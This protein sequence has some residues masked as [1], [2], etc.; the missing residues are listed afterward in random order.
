[1]AQVICILENEPDTD[2][3]DKTSAEPEV[4]KVLNQRGEAFHQLFIPSSHRERAFK[5]IHDETGHMGVERTLELARARFYWL[6]MA[7]Y[8]ETKCKSCDR[9]ALGLFLVFCSLFMF[10][11]QIV[12][13]S[14]FLC[15][16]NFFRIQ[17]CLPIVSNPCEFGPFYTSD[18]CRTVT[19]A[20][21]YYP[22]PIAI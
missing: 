12:Q 8:I 5:G 1:L 16:G 15:Q 13:W 22:F 14:S 20:R 9:C 7:K 2:T 17:F 6:K 10:G 21:R 19:S 4:A 18:P 3:F 11:S